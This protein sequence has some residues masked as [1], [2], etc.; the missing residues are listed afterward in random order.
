MPR[1]LPGFKQAAV[2]RL[3]TYWTPEQMFR[4]VEREVEETKCVGLQGDGNMG[5]TGF[6]PVTP[7]MSR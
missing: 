6:E 4:E 3:D 2:D 7:T 5:G 1:L